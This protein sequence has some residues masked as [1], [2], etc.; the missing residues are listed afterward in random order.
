MISKTR[1]IEDPNALL[2]IRAAAAFLKVSETSLR[3]WTNAGSL[4]CLRVGQR[5]ERRFRL[6]DLVSFMEHSPATRRSVSPRARSPNTH[7]TR[8]EHLTI[9]H[10]NHLCGIYGSNAGRV[11]LFSK[12]LLE[13]LREGSVCYLI[14]ASRARNEIVK[15]LEHLHPGLPADIR[16]GRL[17]FSVYQNSCSE[18][19]KYLEMQMHEAQQAGG[20]SFRAVGDIVDLIE[21]CP[22]EMLVDYEAGLDKVAARF[23]VAVLCAYDARKFS[24][25]ELLNA[26]KMH[27]DT[28]RHPLASLLA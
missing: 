4:P 7:E 8:H 5:R 1:T 15:H 25:V 13:G 12:F 19:L 18:E 22:A 28:F 11:S 24:G 26:L 27:R 21:Q 17:L 20:S 2:D 6:A 23:P 16:D 14:A 10:G 3:R 9:T